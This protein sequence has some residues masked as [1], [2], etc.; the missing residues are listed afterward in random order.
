M[1]ISKKIPFEYYNAFEILK[2]SHE[3]LLE[4]TEIYTKLMFEEISAYLITILVCWTLAAVLM[5]VVYQLYVE[6]TIIRELHQ[7]KCM[8]KVL[9]VSFAKESARLNHYMAKIIKENGI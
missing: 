8:L 9:P 4:E 1:A 7:T 5:T 6:R 2:H 3:R